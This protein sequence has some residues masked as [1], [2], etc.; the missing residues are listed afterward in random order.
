[1]KG[2]LSIVRELEGTKGSSPRDIIT[3]CAFVDLHITF[4]ELSDDHITFLE[5]SDDHKRCTSTSL[6]WSCPTIILLL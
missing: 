5:L 6:S 3:T 4:L 2:S 1:M